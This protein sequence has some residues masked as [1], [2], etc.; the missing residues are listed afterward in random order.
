MAAASFF[1]PEQGGLHHVGQTESMPR[2]FDESAR[3]RKARIRLSC[4]RASGGK[5]NS[6]RDMLNRLHR[7]EAEAAAKRHQ[8]HVG[9]DVQRKESRFQPN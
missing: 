2:L 8:P 4:C 9:A 7:V 6:R 1:P 5:N 3:S